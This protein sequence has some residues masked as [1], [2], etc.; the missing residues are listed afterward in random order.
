MGKV[1]E[2]AYDLAEQTIDDT[3]EKIIKNELSFNKAVKLLKEDKKVNV[4]FSDDEIEMIVGHELKKEFNY[5]NASE[6]WKKVFQIWTRI[7]TFN[8]TDSRVPLE[9]ILNYIKDWLKVN[10][11]SP[12]ETPEGLAQDSANLLEKIEEFE[13]EN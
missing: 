2:W 9:E 1:K 6:H 12:D 4:F 3:I 8:M 5:G 10:I 7:E 13:D 11:D